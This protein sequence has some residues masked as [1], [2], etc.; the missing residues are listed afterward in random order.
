M[1]QTGAGQGGHAAGSAPEPSAAAP[2]RSRPYAS[3]FCPSSVT[4]RYPASPSAKISLCTARASRPV[5]RAAPQSCDAEPAGRAAARS[6]INTKRVRAKARRDFGV[7][8][9][10]TTREQS[11]AVTAPTRRSAS[12]AD[13]RR[14]TA[15]RRCAGYSRRKAA[16]ARPDGVRRAA[17]L[18]AARV[19]HD[20]VRAALVAAVDDINPG[21]ER[22]V[23]P[24]HRDVLRDRH[25][26]HRDHLGAQVHLLQ[27]L[28][29]PAR[30]PAARVAPCRRC[31]HA[32]RD[33]LR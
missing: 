1:L 22:A 15:A 25:R 4:S 30:A 33:A 3:T 7:Q 21:A 14:A 5:G 26:L 10:R 28:A 18:G 23:A 31:S 6:L 13:R 9:S 29:D 32:L 16:A 19:G 8:H 12:S 17:L 20:A 2:G 11:G 27:Q 24:R